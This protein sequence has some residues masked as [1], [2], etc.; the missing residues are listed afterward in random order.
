MNTKTKFCIAIV[1]SLASVFMFS[2]SALSKEVDCISTYDNNICVGESHDSAIAKIPKSF[3]GQTVMQ[4]P[5]GPV[6]RREYNLSGNKFVITYGR[7]ISD[8][9]HRVLKIETKEKAE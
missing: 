1:F 4:G 9:P 7:K 2:T 5:Y 6:V 8:G 3:I